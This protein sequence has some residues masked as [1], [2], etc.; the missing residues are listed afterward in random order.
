MRLLLVASL[1]I[2]AL[3]GQRLTLDWGTYLGIDVSN[4]RMLHGR[5]S[6]G[7]LY[8][9]TAL[10]GSSYRSTLE[11]YRWNNLYIA[12]LDPSGKLIWGT[13]YGGSSTAT[14][15]AFLVDEAGNSYLAGVKY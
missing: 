5:D 11:P 9:A 14:L 6:A 10:I 3:L 15:G 8:V 12:K 4:Y 7:N 2:S 1:S 13:Y